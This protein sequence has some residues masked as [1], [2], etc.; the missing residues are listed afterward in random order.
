MS[1]KKYFKVVDTNSMTGST[2][3]PRDSQADVGFKNYQ[4]HLP[5]V[6]TG[7]PNRVERYTQYETM[8]SDSEINAALDILAE[9]S[10]QTNIENKTPFDIFF[11][12][13]PSDSEV[14]VLKEALHSW[15]SLNDFDKRIF[16][17][18]R[19]YFLMHL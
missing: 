16:K 9:F 15:V 6:Y 3:M 10:T 5:E 8:D 11:K 12:E 13:Q 18:F 7:H 17:M 4:S 14:K 19:K 1:W 2:T